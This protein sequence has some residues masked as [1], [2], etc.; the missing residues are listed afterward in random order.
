[1]PM[2][3]RRFMFALTA[4]AGGLLAALS[5][6]TATAR[7]DDWSIG[8]PSEIGLPSPD[9]VSESGMPPFD[10]SFLEQ[11]LFLVTNLSTDEGDATSGLLTTTDSFGTINQDFV[12]TDPLNTDIFNHSVI[13][14]W[15]LG[16]GYENVYTDLVG[17]GTGGANQ[18]TDTVI[19]P[20]GNFDIPT[21]FDAAALD[22]G[23][24]TAAAATDWAAALDADWTTLAADFSALF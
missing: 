9:L 4:A 18:I 24:P 5:F 16:G 2:N 7:A 12:S 1:M 3:T 17:L 22:F 15:N 13:D 8:D 10:Q 19:T 21:T 14:I 20:F 11:G 23:A 6:S